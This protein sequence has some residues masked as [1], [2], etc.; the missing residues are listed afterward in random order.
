VQEIFFSVILVLLAHLNAY[1]KI[2]NIFENVAKSIKLF[3]ANIYQSQS[4]SHQVL[5]AEGPR[6]ALSV[7]AKLAHYTFIIESVQFNEDDNPVLF[8]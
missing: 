2:W 3:F 8:I 4:E 7:S 6:T 1:T 5:K